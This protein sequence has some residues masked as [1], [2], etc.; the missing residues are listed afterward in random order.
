LNWRF[1]NIGETIYFQINATDN[2][3]IGSRQLVVNNQAVALDNNGIGSYTVTAVGVIMAQ[4]IVTDANGN[5]STSNTTVNV[6]DPTNVEAPVVN[7]TFPT[8]NITGII[9]IV[10]SVTDTNL[11]YYVL[12]VALAGIDNYKEVFRGTSNVTNGLL[13]KFDPSGLAND[14]Y[15]LRLTAFDVNGKGIQVDQ[16]V[17]VA[18]ELKLG[19]FRLSFTDIA[20]PVAGVPITL[21][22]TYDTLT[23]NSKDDFGYGWRM[24]FRDTDLR[25]SLKRDALYEELGYFHSV[26][27]QDGDRVYITLPG[28]KR[29]GFTFRAVQVG[30]K[31]DSGAANILNAVFK[32]K[33]WKAN[34][35]ADKGNTSKLTVPLNTFNFD[36]NGY[37]ASGYGGGNVDALLIRDANGKLTNLMGSVYRPDEAVFGN[38][39][40]L[41]TKDGTVYE[42]N[43]TTGDLESVK[44]T[45]GNKL[46]Y[47]DTEIVSSN[48]QKVVF[49]RDN[50]GRI[51]SVI[52]PLGVKIRYE[53]DAQGDLVGVI[54]RDGN[55]TRYQYNSTQQHYLDKIIDSLGREAVK[56]EYDEKGRLKKTTNAGGAEIEFI[57]DPNNSIETV[58]D[59]LGNA[60]TY[61]YDVR[62]NIVTEVDALGG[63]TRR[64]YDDNNNLLSEIDA[65][66]RTKLHTYDDSKNELSETD[67]LG[68]SRSYRYDSRGRLLISIDE[69]GNKTEYVRDSRG[70]VLT[71]I[72]A[73]GN[74]TTYTYDARGNK[75]T[76]TNALG[77]TTTYSYDIK[78]NRVSETDALGHQISYKYDANGRETEVSQQV[79]LADGVRTIT[80]RKAYDAD[81]NI[82]SETDADG[83][84]VRYQYNKNGKRSLTIDPFNGQ[85]TELYDDNNR[86]ITTVFADGLTTNITYDANG[87][88]LSSTDRNGL[89]TLYT[90]DA[91]NRA[92]SLTAPDS[93]PNNPNDNLKKLIA[94][95]R[96]GLLTSLTDERGQATVFDY[97]LVGNQIRTR[98]YDGTTPIITTAT[99]DQAHRRTSSTDALGRT[100]RHAY[101]N[102]G[103][104]VSNTYADG[105]SDRTVYDDLGKEIIKVDRAGRSTQYEYDALQHLTA[106]TLPAVDGNTATTRYRYGE[107]GFLISQVD[108]IQHETKYEYDSRGLRTAV[109]RPEGQ[110]SST[111]YN[112]FGNVIS[113]TDFN[114]VTSEY[115]Y[116]N[117]HRLSEEKRNGQTIA[118][119]T[120]T[121][122]GQKATIT[123]YR[124]TTR[125]SYRSEG[126]LTEVL[127]PDGTF[128]R[129]VYEG[130]EL[131]S[132]TTPYAMTS[133]TYDSQGRLKTVTA[134]GGTTT[135][136]YDLLGNQIGYVL[137]NGVRETRNYD[138]LNRL[139]QVSQ[140]NSA[141]QLLAEYRYTLDAMGNRTKVVEGDRQTDFT[142]DTRDRLVKEAVTTA[143]GTKTTEYILD[144]VGNRLSKS[145][146]IDGLTTYF[147]NANDWL[148]TEVHGSQSMIYTYDANGNNITKTSS[149]GNLTTYIWNVD[150]RL[151]GIG[152]NGHQFSYEYDR[153]GMRT[154]QTVDG[155]RTNYLLDV[156][157]SNPVVLAEYSQPAI[158]TAVYN[159]GAGLIS[160][161]KGSNESF[162]LLDGHSGVRLLTDSLGG[163]TSTSSYD[164]YGN[165]NSTG[166]NNTYLYRGEQFDSQTQLQYLRAR[167]YDPNT[168]RFLG[169]DPVGGDP[170]NPVSRHR[171]LYGNANPVSYSDPSG[172][173]SI[174]EVGASLAIMNI[175]IGPLYSFSVGTINYLER[176]RALKWEGKSFNA[177]IS[178]A[179]IGL[180]SAITATAN[181]IDLKSGCHNGTTMHGL[182]LLL[183]VGLSYSPL[184]ISATVSPSMS[185]TSPSLFGNGVGVLSGLFS[186][187]TANAVTTVAGVSYTGYF[188]MGLGYGIS[189]SIDFDK[190]IAYGFDFSIGQ[191]TGLSIPLK[192]V[193]QKC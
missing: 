12:E 69:L 15:N 52:D 85:T 178:G 46:T 126:Q 144:A 89:T 38:R 22:R 100:T 25:T 56:T 83:N 103:R 147:Y 150:N 34:F 181:V 62:G 108:A 77:K 86:L 81:G 11:D 93:T 36:L 58:K 78:G 137:A 95:D 98:R 154:A 143:A 127:N 51:V 122:T 173:F 155:V 109:I 163:L 88:Q 160:Q 139:T 13:G 175:L 60:T 165:P 54:D 191:S 117:M 4:A 164:A 131:R 45:N 102:L 16:D 183:G 159:Y 128:V 189:T 97:D 186:F 190:N 138:V 167:Y 71:K 141:G 76:E 84:T 2:V 171:Y 59:A 152:M 28:G 125:Y 9:N 63:I 179:F 49:E 123:D 140:T 130:A 111:R 82:T 119:Y 153:S 10:G 21:T 19:N 70:N 174:A 40:N 156:N 146:L 106:V 187:A 116:D 115:T 32:G 161:Q 47:S 172:K 92:T 6:I 64:I 33:L 24:E 184:P 23:A 43:A 151:T 3:G 110:R 8:D 42:I 87:N 112:V 17:A 149:S 134:N 48:G 75:L 166:A 176:D 55:T 182:W 73:E 162:Y 66:G 65:E 170:N 101:D 124:G 5:V 188:F 96:T 68:N 168:G 118:A 18:S 107:R 193:R 57:Y 133:Y 31:G 30:S 169:V 7:V 113:T 180:P 136:T 79:T 145:D 35:D 37:G 41:T 67:S 135:Y 158:S 80:T 90:Y 177:S 148:L 120:Y 74:R 29:E 26:G 72:D 129:Y 27:F 44:D 99:Y 104:I 105:L 185:I 91:L 50:Q 114:G 121:A 14:T 192:G 20:I 53:Y 132:I 1:A 142:Y 39:Y 61:E 157:R 94:Y